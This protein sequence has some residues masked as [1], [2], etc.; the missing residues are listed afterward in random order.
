MILRSSPPLRPGASRHALAHPP[1]RRSIHRR[2]GRALRTSSGLHCLRA[3]PRHTVAVRDS[4]NPAGP[5]LALSPAAW[6]RFIGRP[7]RGR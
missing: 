7:A 5:M 1:A 2:T 3:V 6:V 4:K